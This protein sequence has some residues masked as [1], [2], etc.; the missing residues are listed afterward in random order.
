MKEILVFIRQHTIWLHHTIIE[1]KLI[2]IDLWSFVHLWSGAI[3]F[4]CLSLLKWKNRWGWLLFFLTAFEIL[5]AFLFIAVLKLFQPEKIP[6][7]FMDIIIG[8]AGGYLVFY[9]FEKSSISKGVSNSIIKVF[10]SISLA[11]FWVGHYGFEYSLNNLN[12]GILNIQAFTLYT[13]MG[14]FLL[15]L[16]EWFEKF[17]IK[18]YLKYF[19]FGLSY[20]FILLILY[21]F[22]AFIMGISEVLHTDHYFNFLFFKIDKV[23]FFF[24]FIAPLVFILFYKWLLHIFK[25]QSVYLKY[26]EFKV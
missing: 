9:L 21:M 5:E 26:Y 2:Y 24:Y 25:K 11:F 22:F 18:T 4:A 8:M 19:L 20:L 15:F 10:S 16:F 1:Y 6:D 7:V 14:Y 23:L 13:V 3:V 17:A 12:L